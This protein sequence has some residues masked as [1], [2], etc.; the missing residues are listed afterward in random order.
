VP[1]T[2]SPERLAENLAVMDF[3]LCP[4]DMATIA[5]LNRNRR[6]NG[7]SPCRHR[8]PVKGLPLHSV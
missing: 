1:K 2:S 6:Y 5:A 3:E 8:R 7:M 4:E